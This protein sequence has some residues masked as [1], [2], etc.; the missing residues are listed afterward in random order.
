MLPPLS[1]NYGDSGL[2]MLFTAQCS[3]LT[4]HFLT[5]D[6]FFLIC[7]IGR[8]D[9]GAAMDDL[10]SSEE[11]TVKT[12]S[13]FKQ[14][15]ILSLTAICLVS[16]SDAQ[17]GPQTAE[18]I[19]QNA[20][21][22]TMDD[23]RSWADAV[24]VGGG[25][26]LYVG[27]V[28]GAQKLKGP[29]SKVIDLS[30][31]M[32]LP[33]FQDSHVHLISGGIELELCNLNG[34]ATKEEIFKKIQ[35][36]A[37]Q[38]PSK[39]WVVGGGWDLTVFPDA[40]P[41]KEDLDRLVPDRPAY[42]T[43]ADGHSSWV[44]SKAL[45]IA[46]L[47]KMT[48]DPKAGRIE[49]KKETGEPSGTLR[50][51]ASELVG[52][53]LPQ[54]SEADFRRGLEEGLALA[55]RFGITSILEASADDDIMKAYSEFDRSGKLTVRVLASLFV[56][57]RKDV[58]QVADLI[59][60]RE[61]YRGHFLEAT[62]AKIFADGVIESG[63]AALLEPYLNR[64]A[65]RGLP[66]LE[67]ELLNRLAV[68]LDKEGFQIHIHAIGDYA[69]RMSL[70]ALELAE[71]TNGR[72]DARH[73][74]AHLELINPKDIP[75]FRQ[76]GVVSNF[77]ALWAYPD[78][79]ITKF[80]EPVL[81]PERSRWLYPIGSI[82]KSG[83]MIVGG[84]DWSVSSLNPLDAIQVGITRRSLED[85]SGQSWIQEELVDLPTMLAAYTIN[86]AYLSHQEK[87]RGSLEPGKAADLVVLERNLFEIPP[88]QI[89]TVKVLL[90]LLEGKTVYR[91][92]EMP[93]QQVP[94]I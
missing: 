67:P 70:D 71:R 25:K 7:L 85:A 61:L 50:E 49:R 28:A 17:K 56:E 19:L 18:I 48:P 26:I 46:G 69:I 88:D 77:Q 62:T 52:K 65:Y 86:G 34:L 64:P 81:G 68:V 60:K 76:L 93:P 32:V 20:A 53:H 11:E 92:S 72:R 13:F 83:G 59:K 79:Y 39:S 24:A 54:T 37:A 9:N 27:T 23:A 51:S 84:S 42:I 63:T 45:E 5:G 21:I 3:Q 66:N 14:A 10:H 4:A 89:H 87:L 16:C 41:L 22:Y 78:A 30:G 8:D 15:I 47:T 44:N 90:A 91:G 57:P 58:A 29:E 55:N 36:Y 1:D 80:T 6:D 35:D 31:R 12:K 94:K 73:H 43:S 2:L 82:V 33:G 75:R 38:N 40:N 74:I